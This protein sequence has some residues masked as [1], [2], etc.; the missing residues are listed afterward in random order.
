M[1]LMLKDLYSVQKRDDIKILPWSRA[2]NNALLNDNTILFLT[3]NTK[4]WDQLKMMLVR[5]FYKILEFH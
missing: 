2:Y 4:G 3:A 1:D 5:F